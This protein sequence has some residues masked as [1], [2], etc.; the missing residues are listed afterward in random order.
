MNDQEFLQLVIE[1]E[2]EYQFDGFSNEDAYEIGLLMLEATKNYPGTVAVEITVND[3]TVFR[4]FPSNRGKLEERWLTAKKNTVMT[5]GK[6][7]LRV[8]LELN[9]KGVP[10]DPPSMFPGEYVRCGGAFPIRL[11]NGSFIGV[12]ATSGL[13]DT[14][15]NAI[16][17]D[18]LEQFFA[19][20]KCN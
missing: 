11:R 20:R 13:I 19:R 8:A 14:D 17:W 1:K 18:A 15:D 5:Y 10:Q 12:I 2:N 6:S 7:S 3:F 9:I 16:I 4:Y